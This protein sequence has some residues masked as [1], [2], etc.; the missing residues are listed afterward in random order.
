[1]T[2]APLDTHKASPEGVLRGKPF[3]LDESGPL[4]FCISASN[5]RSKRQEQFIHQPLGKKV[6]Q[7][8]R[9]TLN[10]DQL[11]LKHMAYYCLQDRLGT[12]YKGNAWCSQIAKK[13]GW[14]TWGE[15]SLFQDSQVSLRITAKA[16]LPASG[17]VPK[18]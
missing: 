3:A 9:P 12:D 15:K 14:Q 10:Q 16:E 5:L 18:L 11:T 17:L 8:L 2:L 13:L 4:D 6:P 7:Q 1:V